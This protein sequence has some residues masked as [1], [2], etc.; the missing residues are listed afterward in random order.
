M[1]AAFQ[2]NQTPVP[3]FICPSRRACQL[4]PLTGASPINS[5]SLTGLLV[6]KSDYAITCGTGIAGNPG[7]DQPS[8][9]NNPQPTSYAEG[10]GQGFTWPDYSSP[11]I[12]SGPNPDFQSGVSFVRSMVTQ[13]QIER[14]TAHMIMLGE[15]YLD[16]VH[17]TDGD[18]GGDNEVLFVGQD[19]DLFRTTDAPPQQDTAGN[20]E[21]TFFGSAHPAGC[22]FAACD[23]SVHF[24]S[25]EVD[26]LLFIQFG[27]RNIPPAP[28]T[29]GGTMTIWEGN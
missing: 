8:G 3:T 22:N 2:V 26:A 21:Q 28:G 17:Y 4:Y 16:P 23:G 19:N 12:S 24:V 29:I 9:Q 18:D 10:N 11:T 7:D 27:E 5:D 13:A 25:Y 20:D 6:N 14:G 15:K 1:A